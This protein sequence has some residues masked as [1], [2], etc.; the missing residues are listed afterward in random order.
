[1]DLSHTDSVRSDLPM[2]SASLAQS[3]RPSE[4]RRSNEPDAKALRVRA[5][6]GLRAA[7]ESTIAGSD[8][9]AC[10]S[11]LA[12]AMEHAL[13]SGGGRLRPMLCLAVAEAFGDPRPGLAAA[14]ASAVE[15]IH[16]ASLVH[17]DLPCFDDAELRRGVPTVHKRF[18]EATA[19]LVGDALIVHAFELLATSG[20]PGDR[21]GALVRVLARATGA[22]GGLV[23]GQAWE[24]SVGVD[25]R[26]YRI[27][28]TA[29]LFGAAAAMGAI[30]AGARPDPWLALGTEVGDCYQI[31]DDLFDAAGANAG[32]VGKAPGK[33]AA[34]GRPTATAAG[35][36]A[37][38]AALSARL[39][40]MADRIPDCPR[41]EVLRR[42]I[43]AFEERVALLAP[44]LAAAPAVNNVVAIERARTRRKSAEH[45]Q[46]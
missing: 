17:D 4:P 14:A 38:A 2:G 7:L 34:L 41:P 12:E 5:E 42:W 3:D 18:G 43:G 10:P 22:R 40:S 36:E 39:R 28:K 16:C 9:E 29:G 37:A 46:P 6:E 26:A 13:L 45:A 35:F 11:V 30:A 1:M 32:S 33:D 44:S 25:P 23:A 24:S 8:D 19:V 21:M 31:A 15:L 27:A 20:A